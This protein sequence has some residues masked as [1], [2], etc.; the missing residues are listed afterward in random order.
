MYLDYQPHCFSIYITEFDWRSWVETSATKDCRR[1]QQ[2]SFHQPSQY[3][4][5]QKYRKNRTSQ[6]ASLFNIYVSEKQYHHDNIHSG[7]PMPSI[8][9]VPIIPNE[10]VQEH[11]M[12][13]RPLYSGIST[14]KNSRGKDALPSYKDISPNISTEIHTKQQYDKI[15]THE[16][17]DSLVLE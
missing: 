10:P 4:D 15:L 14:T 12:K 16:Y 7:I 5:L 1:Q 13:N 17:L 6:Y 9:Y 11:H 8:K 2:S 3:N